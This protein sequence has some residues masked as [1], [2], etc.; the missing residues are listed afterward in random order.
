MRTRRSIASSAAGDLNIICGATGG[1]LSLP[2]R[3][4]VVWDRIAALELEFLL[5]QLPNGRPVATAQP[6]VLADT[7]NVPTYYSLQQRSPANADRQ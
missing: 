7:R 3:E 5:P 2:E 1:A 6:D 4:R